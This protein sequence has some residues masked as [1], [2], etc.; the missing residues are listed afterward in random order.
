MNVAVKLHR[1]DYV[2]AR[3]E[4]D[5]ASPLLHAGGDGIRNRS[6]VEGD[7]ISLRAKTTNVADRRRLGKEGTRQQQENQRE[8]EFSQEM[9]PSRFVSHVQVIYFLTWPFPITSYFV[10]VSSARAKGPRQ[11]NFCVLTPISAPKPNSPPSEKRVEAFQYTAAEST[12]RR[13]RR[14]CSS[15]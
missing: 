10:E 15:S 2:A 13:K 3:R 1:A 12:W 11:C 8:K 5:G 14:A 7:A 6:G 9:S 4:V